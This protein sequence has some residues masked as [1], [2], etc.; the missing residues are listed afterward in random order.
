MMRPD[1]ASLSGDDGNVADSGRAKHAAVAF[2]FGGRAQRFGVVVGKLD[3]LPAFNIGHLADQ[4][5]RV[6]A[7]ATGR[8]AAPE[9]V[10][11]QSA[12]SGAEP[13]AA[14]GSPFSPV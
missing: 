8:I 9:I 3:C 6:K 4:A 13:D 7:V 12:P 14:A 1:F 10:G 5:D 11:E 2:D